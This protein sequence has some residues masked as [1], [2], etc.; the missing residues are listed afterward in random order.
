M[1]I[2]DFVCIND[3]VSNAM[4]LVG[5]ESMSDGAP[6]GF[7][8]GM[9]RLAMNEL[10]FDTYF[11]TL[12][13]DYFNWNNDGRRV[14]MFPKGAFN[15]KEIY[16]FNGDQF[17]VEKSVVINPAR[18]YKTHPLGNGY[19]RAM[20]DDNYNNNYFYSVQ[21]GMIMISNSCAPYDAIRV[22]FNG[23]S[24]DIGE[25]P[26][27]PRF[28]EKHIM[29]SIKVAFYERKKSFDREARLNWIDAKNDTD[30]SL[31]DV[32]RRIFRSDN[33]VRTYMEKYLGRANY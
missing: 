17:K 26:I 19:T 20:K 15:L 8:K 2:N 3:I 28:M 27:V 11:S 7:Y 32:K 13:K 5:N 16:A 18:R 10:S 4:F 6:E 29:N 24:G 1:T 9:A 23:I 21:N 31:L 30:D 33:D 22:V 14:I 12:H 25:E